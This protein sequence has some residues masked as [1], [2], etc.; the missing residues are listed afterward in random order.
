M[1]SIHA[2]RVEGDS[3]ANRKPHHRTISIHALRVEGDIETMTPAELERLF[4]STP[5]VWRATNNAAVIA[6][7]VVFLSTPS[8]WRATRE[9]STAR[10][11]GGVISIHALR[12]EGDAV[13][14]AGAA[15][16][17]QFLSTPSVW[18]ATA[19]SAAANAVLIQFLS[20]PSVW[21]ATCG[22]A[23]AILSTT[24]FYPRPPCGGRRESHNV[25]C[26][27]QTISIHALRVEG[28]AGLCLNPTP[29]STFLSTP[30][31]WRATQA[32]DLAKQ[33]I[34]IS[35]HALRV[36]GDPGAGLSL[37]HCNISIHALRVEGDPVPPSFD[38]YILW[39]S[40]HALRVEGD[41]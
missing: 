8:V 12:V 38:Q 1:I 40:I 17:G 30:S 39:I 14:L 15:S 27:Y 5:S 13:C 41:G 2:L 21:R 4:L 10:P 29:T 32:V 24:N 18:R 25:R 9:N 19:L 33:L 26:K 11:S 28:D 23:C 20:T 36:E 7:L 6:A 31:V 16:A 34:E 37:G 22:A 35:I 3:F